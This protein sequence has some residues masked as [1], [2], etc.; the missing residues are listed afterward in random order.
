MVEIGIISTHAGREP[1]NTPDLISTR[2]KLSK[3]LEWI[4]LSFFC[5]AIFILPFSKAMLEIFF[6]LSAVGWF[7]F[8]FLNKEGLFRNRF[9]AFFIAAFIITSSISAFHSDYPDLVF[10]GM[11]KIIRYGLL[12]IMVYDLFRVRERLAVLGYLLVISFSL[13]A[14]DALAQLIT[15][16]DLLSGIKAQ[17]TG[18]HIRLSG[19]FRS[20]G[21][22]AAYLIAMLSIFWGLLTGAPNLKQWKK[23]ALFLL[24]LI[25]LFLL[26]KTH[27]RGAWIAAIMAW[28]PL[29]F[30]ASKR[31]VL[32]VFCAVL[33]GAPFVIPKDALLHLDAFHREQSLVER[34]LL[35]SRAIQVIKA[36]P[37]FGCGINTY[38]QN[39]SKFQDDKTWRLFNLGPLS[40]RYAAFG[41]KESWRIP[42]D[43]SNN[44]G[45][46]V[47]NGFL[48]LAA[49]TGLV[50]LALFLTL[51]A[52]A[53]KAGFT[54]LKKANRPAQPLVWGLISGFAALILQASIDTTLHNLQ[55]AYLI[56]LFIGLLYASHDAASA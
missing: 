27:S 41:E 22:L 6:V 11:V 33:A 32:I 44:R 15:G 19:P 12:V 21:L 40:E 1:M 23:G 38:I 54:A 2:S 51:I 42:G 49:E 53:F 35:W 20:F 28:I 3:K 4:S 46:Y 10:R 39:Y 13:V 5:G 48:Q 26:Y 36:K 29:V 47:H 24:F 14:L 8:K 31:W 55:S 9:L 45:F 34:N 50:S 18:A 56:W 43:Q 17:Y 30:L 25:G 37:L 16:S 52:G 7:G